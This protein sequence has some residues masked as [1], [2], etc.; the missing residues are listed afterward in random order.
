MFGEV[1]QMQFLQEMGRRGG[2]GDSTDRLA[3]SHVPHSLLSAEAGPGSELAPAWPGGGARARLTDK[4]QTDG[5]LAGVC[6]GPGVCYLEVA[7]PHVRPAPWPV[8]AS[9]LIPNPR[10]IKFP[11]EKLPACVC[12]WCQQGCLVRELEPERRVRSLPTHPPAETH[13]EGCP[14]AQAWGDRLHPPSCPV[15][16]AAVPCWAWSYS[17]T[18]SRRLTVNVR[19]Q[20]REGATARGGRGRLLQALLQGL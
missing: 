13:R 20:G 5:S 3:L 2:W 8:G 18:G 11:A 15:T 9:V 6:E 16:T 17:L 10:L 14:G 19:S 7:S 4:M 12:H 1:A